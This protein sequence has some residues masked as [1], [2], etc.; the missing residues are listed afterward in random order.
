MRR[1]IYLGLICWLTG[2]VGGRI[3]IDIGGGV[4]GIAREN[5]GTTHHID[6]C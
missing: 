5:V 6:T 4:M 3:S 1:A 2:K